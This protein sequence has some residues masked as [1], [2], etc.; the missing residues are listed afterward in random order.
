M[1]HL[2][3]TLVHG[4]SFDEPF[5]SFDALSR[6]LRDWSRSDAVAP[7]RAHCRRGAKAALAARRAGACDALVTAALLHRLGELV[8]I[9]AAPGPVPASASTAAHLGADLLVDL[10]PPLVTEAVR[11]LPSAQRYLAPMTLPALCRV[12]LAGLG[13]AG[14]AVTPMSEP[15]RACFASLPF[16]MNAVKLCRWT[17][18]AE[19]EAA[20]RVDVNRDMPTLLRIA[21][22]TVCNDGFGW[23]A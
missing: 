23:G 17:L 8:L 4:L 5:A 19:I 21:Q 22:R 15:E 18:A 1:E 16:A 9:D 7:A 11:L 13:Y 20:E 2:M 6:S 3:L 14:S 12:A 10:Y